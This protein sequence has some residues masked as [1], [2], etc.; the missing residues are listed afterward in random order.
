M[1]ADIEFRRVRHEERG[2]GTRLYPVSSAARQWCIDCLP[3]AAVSSRRHG[4]YFVPAAS[5]SD[6]LAELAAEGF[7]VA[8]RQ[9]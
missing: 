8:E 6:V 9:A 1:A 5:E 4:S 3:D 2:P 7:A